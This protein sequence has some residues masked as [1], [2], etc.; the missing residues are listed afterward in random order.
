MSPGRGRALVAWLPPLLWCGLIFAA[1][2]IP[3]STERRLF[4]GAD[5]VAHLAEYGVLGF[6]LARALARSSG[7]PSAGRVVLLGALLG[8]AWGAADEV[9]QAF[10]PRRA[11]EWGDAAADAAGSLA[12]AAAYAFRLRRRARGG[13]AAAATASIGP[14][15][16][17]RP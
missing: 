15:P 11:P 17:P 3:S 4:P 7:A 13:A 10:V 5:K 6:L 9:H 2:S 1:S 14:A 16:G 12:G 8:A